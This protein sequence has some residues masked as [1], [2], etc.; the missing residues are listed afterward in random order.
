MRGLKQVTTNYS[1]M[2]EQDTIGP[3][4][5]DPPAGWPPSIPWPPHFP[6]SALGQ[7]KCIEFCMAQGGS[8]EV[9]AILCA[10]LHGIPNPN[11]TGSTGGGSTAT[12]PP[13]SHGVSDAIHAIDEDIIEELKSVS[14]HRSNAIAELERAASNR[15]QGNTAVAEELAKSA[16]R[17]NA[18][19]NEIEI[20]IKGK[21]RAKRAAEKFK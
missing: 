20:E 1:I 8:L 9:C 10:I 19:A 2:P 5:K 17:E 7:K 21:E 6:P 11:G 13:S 4:P 16:E 3:W 14:R 15:A 18:R 12:S